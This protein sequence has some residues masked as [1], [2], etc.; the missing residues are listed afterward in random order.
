MKA[1]NCWRWLL[2]KLQ[3][4]LLLQGAKN[5]LHSVW[6]TVGCGLERGSTLL[7][8][9]KRKLLNPVCDKIAHI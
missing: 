2:Q 9:L 6:R 5:N 7:Y 1:G 4:A 3:H 8:F